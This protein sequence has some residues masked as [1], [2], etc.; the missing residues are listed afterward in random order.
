MKAWVISK[1]SVRSYIEKKNL[2]KASEI[3]EL[4]DDIVLPE[5]SDD[6][7]LIKLSSTGLNFNSVWSSKLYPVD[8]FTL[9]NNHIRR[10]RFDKNQSIDVKSLRTERTRLTNSSKKLETSLEKIKSDISVFEKK[11][12]DTS[13]SD[14]EGLQS[15]SQSLEDLNSRLEEQEELWLEQASRIEEI[16]NILES[17]GRL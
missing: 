2:P 16:T 3:M 7:A 5:I 9:L 11:S 8:P 12:L 13:P 14:F 1:S 15:I 10:N 6:Q 4:K 17:I